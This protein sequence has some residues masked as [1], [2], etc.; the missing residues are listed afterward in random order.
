MCARTD[1][2]LASRRSVGEGRIMLDSKRETIGRLQSTVESL[3]TFNMVRST[4]ESS[5]CLDC[6][7]NQYRKKQRETLKRNDKPPKS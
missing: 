2:V 7:P 1:D 5:A 3:L 6:V 4:L